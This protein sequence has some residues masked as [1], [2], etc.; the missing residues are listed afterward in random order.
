MSSSTLI[1]SFAAL[2]AVACAAISPAASAETNWNGNY[3]YERTFTDKTGTRAGEVYSIKLGAK[4]ACRI[5][6]T[7]P[8]SHEDIICRTAASDKSVTLHFKR[9]A[10]A[11]AVAANNSRLYKKD[12]RLLTLEK[13]VNNRPEAIRTIWHNLRTMD[14]AKPASGERF[15][16]SK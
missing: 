11:K 1:R 16:R 4:G 10:D 9:H 7:G 2:A 5:T 8:A 15:K 14:G 13:G 12:L 3:S 6:M